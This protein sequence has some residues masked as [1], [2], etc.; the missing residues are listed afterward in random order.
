LGSGP[1]RKKIL[2]WAEKRGW[3]DR[4]KVVLARHDEA[5]RYLGAA[6]LMVAPSQT[7]G[8]WK[9]QFGVP[10]EISIF[11]IIAASIFKTV[12]ILVWS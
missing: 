4:V 10:G 8:N 7:T 5:P 1:A 2:R 3:A 11:V 6:D 9:E 12:H